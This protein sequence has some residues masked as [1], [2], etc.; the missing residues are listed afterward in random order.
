MA[1]FRDP[2]RT[3][4]PVEVIERLLEIT[5]YYGH[6]PVLYISS[7]NDLATYLDSF[8][9]DIYSL[10]N[11]TSE[12]FETTSRIVSVLP[13]GSRSHESATAH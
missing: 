5:D 12:A 6:D 10:T 13:N 4:S 2:A 9:F 11:D 8:G 1:S 7:S 3:F